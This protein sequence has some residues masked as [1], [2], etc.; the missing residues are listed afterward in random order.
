LGQPY[1]IFVGDAGRGGRRIGWIESVCSL[2]KEKERNLF[3]SEQFIINVD[4]KWATHAPFPPAD[5]TPEEVAACRA[6]WHGAEWA[7]GLY[8]LAIARDP[9]LRSLR[10]LEGEA[11]AAMCEAMRDELRAAAWRVYGVPAAKLR[12]FF[13]YTVVL[14]HSP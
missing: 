13:H 1:T 3:A 10:D 12:V 8:L 4:T 11:G 6:A 14:L 5:A 2:E 9:A 7:N